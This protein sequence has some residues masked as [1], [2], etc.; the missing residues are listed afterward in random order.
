MALGRQM[1]AEGHFQHVTLDEG[2]VRR[3]FEAL[4]R[5]QFCVVHEGPDGLDGG[6]AGHIGEFWFSR[7][8]MA[9]DVAFFVRPNRR[10]SLAAVRLVQAFVSWAA[11]RGAAEV[12]I[13]QSS[14]V[15]I[16]ETARLLTGMGFSY[17]GGCYKWRIGNV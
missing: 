3:A 13:V 10:G 15:R 2:K 4:I 6:F 1:H 5:D 8:L 9:S 17:V 16:E 14:A 12:S 11:E 7:A